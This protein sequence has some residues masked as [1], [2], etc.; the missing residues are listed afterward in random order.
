MKEEYNMQKF[1]GI[2]LLLFAVTS[3]IL[4]Y[5]HYNNNNNN[6]DDDDIEKCSYLDVK[7]FE[8]EYNINLYV[9]LLLKDNVKR[10][11]PKIIDENFSNDWI[12]FILENN[13]VIQISR[14]NVLIITEPK[15]NNL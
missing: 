14:H 1:S 5:H 9:Y 12:I 7:E 10:I 2:I 11:H 15:S 13:T 3:I 4:Y 6:D 8:K